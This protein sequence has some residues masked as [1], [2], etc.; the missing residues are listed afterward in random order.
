MALLTRVAPLA[1][2][3]MLGSLSHSF[4]SDTPSRRSSVQSRRSAQQLSPQ[5]AHGDQLATSGV[6]SSHPFQSW[7]HEYLRG[8]GK[9]ISA[10]GG[11]P[12]THLAGALMRKPLLHPEEIVLAHSSLNETEYVPPIVLSYSLFVSRFFP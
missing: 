8:I 2:A 5:I 10:E 11:R 12:G 9:E 1:L 3:L 6:H 4:C 7:L